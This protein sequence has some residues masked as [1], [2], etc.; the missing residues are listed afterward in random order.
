MASWNDKVVRWLSEWSNSVE[1]WVP[2]FYEQPT[3]G[4]AEWI[5]L[6]SG[7][8]GALLGACIGAAVSWFLQRQANNIALRRDEEGRKANSQAQLFNALT[9]ITYVLADTKAT[10]IFFEEAMENASK[11]GMTDVPLGAKVTYISGA[12]R[13]QPIVAEE[14]APISEMKERQLI[15]D[16]GEVLMQHSVMLGNIVEFNDRQR[17]LLQNVDARLN[18]DGIAQIMPDDLDRHRIKYVQVSQLAAHVLSDARAI[19]IKAEH[20]KGHLTRAALKAY[21]E[22]PTL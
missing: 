11:Q 13:S 3:F 2:I 16:Y 1:P 8:G 9:R 21:P 19:S 15:A 7:L 12:G 6:A 10:V 14:I 18:Q 22:F 20:V 4:V 17:F 5:S